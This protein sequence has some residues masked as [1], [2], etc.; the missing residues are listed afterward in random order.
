[1]SPSLI[2]KGIMCD[3]ISRE[4]GFVDHFVELHVGAEHF[5]SRADA[6]VDW[7][8]IEWVLKKH[9]KKQVSST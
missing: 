3:Q 2:V 7:S 5:L 4:K 9:Y 8:P 6:L 1:M